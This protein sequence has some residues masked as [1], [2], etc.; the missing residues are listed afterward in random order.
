MVSRNKRGT[1]ANGRCAL[2]GKLFEQRGD[3]REHVIPNAIGGRKK[4]RG[5]LCRDCN[6]SA[7]AMWDDE[8]A[9]QLNPICNL[10]NI[11]RERGSPPDLVVKTIKGRRMRHRSDGHMSP[12]RYERS[13]RHEEGKVIVQATAPNMR[14][15]RRNL[16]G[17]RRKYPQLK[18]VDLLEHAVPKKEYVSEAMHIP[19][20]FGG[21][22]AG[23]SM[24]KSCVALAHVAGVRLAELECAR[25]YLG[26]EDEP[27]FGYYNEQDVV[28]NRPTNTFF[29]CVYVKGDTVTGKVLGYVE[30]FGYQRVV[31]MLSD[32][33]AGR[34]FSECYAIDPVA[35]Q[36]I[37]LDVQ[38]PDFT[39]DE[40]E[41][42]YDYKKVSYET[43]R[44]A[45]SG[46]ME[47][48]LEKAGERAR[49]KAVE[50]AMEFAFGEWGVE[51]GEII[52][53]EDTR[54]LAALITER[55]APFVAH[56]LATPKF[57]CDDEINA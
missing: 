34:A 40:I 19:L 46:L 24:V 31:V 43:V 39:D 52:T 41:Q 51:E 48:Y 49:S 2:C 14:E 6:S 36:E 27:C 38:L 32:S 25:K 37:L 26:G 47:S 18:D 28:V 7:G 23:R 45:V 15:L 22:D 16:E 53:E 10:L 30:Y 56:Q 12:N 57:D 17:L 20:S 21:L 5:F 54:R 13:E 42:I 9:K 55:L 44:I 4:I 1:S 33:Y 3:S 50:D 35:G 29:H 11:S 8:L